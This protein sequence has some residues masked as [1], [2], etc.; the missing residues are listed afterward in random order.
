MSDEPREAFEQ[1]A[2]QLGAAAVARLDIEAT[3]AGVVQRLRADVRPWWRNGLIRLAAV[4]VVVL[5]AGVLVRSAVVER[6]PTVA[7][8]SA[9]PELQ[10][11]AVSQ[12]EEMLDSLELERPVADLVRPGLNDLTTSELEQLLA[13]MEG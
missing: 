13:T 8:V 6:R 2:P 3:A 7:V 5:G 10:N 11:L 9:P 12:L 4:M 1:L